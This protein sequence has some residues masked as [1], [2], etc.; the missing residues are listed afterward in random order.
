[1]IRDTKLLREKS[2][3]SYPAKRHLFMSVQLLK[4]I[5]ITFKCHLFYQQKS[6][7]N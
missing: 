1:M 7:V 5:D 4:I 3:N 2:Y 6:S